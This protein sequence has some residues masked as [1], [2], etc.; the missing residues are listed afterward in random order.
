MAGTKKLLPQKQVKL[1]TVPL[2]DELSVTQLFPLLQQDREFMMY[3]PR[4]LP[5]GR[6]PDR[7]YFF[8]VLNT[9]NEAYLT[10]LIEHAN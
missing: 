10:S 5:K 9:L 3:M 1:V 4:K 6:L 7:V 2:F 8:N